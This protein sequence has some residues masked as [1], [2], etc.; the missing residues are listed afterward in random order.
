MA[1]EIGITINPRRLTVNDT[2]VK[3]VARRTE[4]SFVSHIDDNTF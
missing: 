1:V 2:A 4:L 3:V